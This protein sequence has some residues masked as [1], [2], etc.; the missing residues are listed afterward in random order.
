MHSTGMTEAVNRIDGV[1][2]FWWQSQGEVFFADSIDTMTGKFLTALI[3][4]E[5]VLISGFWGE[6]VVADI[7]L[8]E[9]RGFDLELYESVTVSLAQDSKCFLLWIEVIEV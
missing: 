1:E 3:D 7:E 4:K 2:S 5:A 6:A 9:L 8:E